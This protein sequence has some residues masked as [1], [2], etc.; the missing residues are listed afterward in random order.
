MKKYVLTLILLSTCCATN[1][2]QN[3]VHTDY[4]TIAILA[5]DKEHTLPLY[6]SCIEQQTWPKDK[7]YIYIRTNNNT[8]N[9]VTVLKEWCEKHQ[10]HYADIFFDDTDVAE[11]V[12]EY[13]QHEWNGVRFKVL[14]KIRQ[15]SVNWAHE[16]NSHYFVI[17]CDNFVLP[18]TVEAMVKTNMAIVAPFLRC[19]TNHWYSNFHVV[20]DENGYY[21]PSP[22]YY[23]FLDQEIKGL[24]DVEVVHCT[25]L[26]RHEVLDKVSYDDDSWRYEY[27]IFSDSARK[28]HI[29][30]YLDNRK[31]YGY[32][33]FAETEEEFDQEQDFLHEHFMSN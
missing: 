32:V 5:K 13:K 12:E 28:Q 6:L 9:T 2:Q 24:I 18:E 25:Y 19:T 26:I 17:D 1:S 30:Q 27:V 10:H 3:P 22:F 33:T 31:I 21:G 4:V 11:R 23:N 7:T 29:P 8:D 20:T 15:D 14:G 16:H